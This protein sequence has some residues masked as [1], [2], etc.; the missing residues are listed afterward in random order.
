[1]LK[2]THPW[3][4]A[5]IYLTRMGMYLASKSATLKSWTIWGGVGAFSERRLSDCSAWGGLRRY[6]KDYLQGLVRAG[7]E[8]R[9]E[10]TSEATDSKDIIT[11]LLR[12]NRGLCIPSGS[13]AHTHTHTALRWNRVKCELSYHGAI[14]ATSHDAVA[15]MESANGG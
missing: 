4:R 9:E 11:T 7:T 5:D 12:G 6:N 10:G 2:S 1:M 13:P 8:S 3:R 14:T 15:G